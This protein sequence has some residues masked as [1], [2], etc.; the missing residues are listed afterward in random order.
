[1]HVNFAKTNELQSIAIGEEGL[2]IG[3][4][5]LI[6]NFDCVRSPIRNLQRIGRTGRSRDGRVVWL[7]MFLSTNSPYRLCFVSHHSYLCFSIK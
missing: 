6:I 2:D 7:G 4:V 5:D 1:M 3:S